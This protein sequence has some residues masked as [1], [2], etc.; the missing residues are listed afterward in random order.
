MARF[1]TEAPPPATECAC[2]PRQL[3]PVGNTSSLFTSPDRGYYAF[4]RAR[5][6]S[7]WLGALRGERP[8]GYQTTAS[9]SAVLPRPRRARIHDP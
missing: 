4:S 7:G 9:Q 2:V 1:G 3:L 5:G 8:F 6:V